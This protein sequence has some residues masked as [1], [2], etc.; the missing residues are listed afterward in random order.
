M[1]KQKVWINRKELAEKEKENE[2]SKGE[3]KQGQQIEDI[4]VERSKCE[5]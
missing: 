2:M 1:N 3:Y 4:H 5:Q